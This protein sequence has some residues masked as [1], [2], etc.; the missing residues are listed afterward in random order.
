[1]GKRR[2]F[3]LLSRAPVNTKK[4]IESAIH[5]C[6][7][8]SWL[9]IKHLPFDTS[10]T[11]YGAEPRGGSHKLRLGETSESKGEMLL[12]PPPHQPSHGM[13]SRRQRQAGR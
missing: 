10:P 8:I 6:T 5:I 11:C 4:G 9:L 12:K 3:T 13:D 7:V 2:Y 1:M